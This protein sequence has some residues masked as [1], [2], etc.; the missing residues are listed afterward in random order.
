MA[1]KRDLKPAPAGTL[2]MCGGCGKTSR[3]GSGWDES[4]RGH[5]I[6]VIASTIKRHG[7]GVQATAVP[8]SE[9]LV[10]RD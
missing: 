7:H 10:D 1:T 5:A 2:W 6:L 9:A 4:C 3:D 8:D